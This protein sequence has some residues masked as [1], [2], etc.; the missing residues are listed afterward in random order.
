[1][2]QQRD[3]TRCLVCREPRVEEFLDL[4]ETALANEFLSEDELEEPEA[5]YPLRVGFCRE[6]GHVQLTERVPPAEMFDE[7]LYVSSASSTLRRHFRDLSDTLVERHGLGENDLVVDIGCNDTS[8]LAAFKDHG[9]RTLG[10]DPAENLAEFADRTGVDRFTGYFGAETAE[11]IVSR[12]GRATLVT[13]TNTFP[14]IP[15][16]QDFVRGIDTLLAPG[17]TFVIEAHYLVDLLDQL[18]FDTVY[19]EHVSYWSLRAVARLFDD[20]G[21]R[22]VK[23]E[24]LPLHHGQLRASIQREG[25][26]EPDASVERVLSRER[27]AGIHRPE[28]W[29]QFSER[30]EGIREDLVGTLRALQDRGHRL[31][32]YG[33]P[34]KGSTLLEY[35]GI[36]P[37]VLD[38]IADISPLK[39]GLYMPGTHIPIVPP[40]RLMT[41]RPDY[42]L[43]LAWNFAEEILGQQEEFLR[44]G[45]RF[46]LPV[47]EVRILEGE[48]VEHA[49][50]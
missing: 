17:G 21:M 2:S 34:A 26:G 33:A 37:D 36:G 31:A 35:M 8:L 6:C 30:V 19:H 47:P 49:L 48:T 5:R 44:Q 41:D 13:A 38:F 32:G 11:E 39:Q 28:T 7:Y 42:V 50:D 25:E 43:L 18:A 4:G 24:H 10:V 20:H 16:L 23:A 14:H 29:R 46:I 27:E 40:E 3:A 9:V 1:M 45:G 15:D 12:W 22:V